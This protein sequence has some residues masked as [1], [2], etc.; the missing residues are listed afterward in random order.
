MKQ[1]MGQWILIVLALF[2]FALLILVPLISIFSNAFSQGWSVFC[3]NIMLPDVLAALR[4]TLVALIVTLPINCVFG[5]CAAW[6]ITKCEFPGKSILL[7]LIDLPLSVSPVIS[8]LVFIFLLGPRTP[9]GTWLL[10]KGIPVIFSVPGIIIATLFVTFPIIARELIPLM[11][12]QGSE[13]EEAALILGASGWQTFWKVTFPNIKW[14]FIYGMILAGSRAIGEFG[15]V[16]VVSGHIRGQT[17]TLPLEVEILYNDYNTSGAF[18]AAAL[19]A[20][21]SILSLLLK[22]WIEH[23]YE[24]QKVRN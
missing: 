16:S 5:L 12:A 14:G 3:Q 10:E 22:K 4:L 24:K 9:I 23:Q 20:C 15:A 17:N 1:K 11:Q 19:L 7:S 18:S 6:A 8:G 13:E 2:L 21:I